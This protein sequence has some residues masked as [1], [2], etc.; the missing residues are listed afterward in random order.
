MT[1]LPASFASAMP[2]EFLLFG[3]LLLSIAFIHWN[4]MAM[5]LVGALAITLY[6]FVFSTFAEGAGVAGLLAHVG[7]EWVLLANLLGLLLGFALLARHVEKSGLPAL[8][9]KYLPNGATGGFLLLVAVFVLSSV[10]DNIAAAIIGAAIAHSV[11]RGRIHVGYLASLVA[12]ANAGGVGSV[13]GDTTTTMIW[14]AGVPPLKVFPGYVAAV[15]AFL[16]TAI[17]ASRQQ[18]AYSPIVADAPSGVRLDAPRLLIVAGVLL[19]AVATNLLM[20]LYLRP[21]ADALPFLAIAV[22]VGLLASAAWRRPDWAELPNALQGAIF[23][24]AL[25]WCASLMPVEKLPVA[26]W[27]STL[28]VGFLS[29]VLDNIPLTALAIKQGGYDWGMLAYAVGFGGSML[30]FGSSA[31][32]AVANRHPEAKS[33]ARWLQHGWHVALAYPVGYFVM[34]ALLGW[35]PFAIDHAAP[36]IATQPPHVAAVNGRSVPENNDVLPDNGTGF[37]MQGSLGLKLPS[38]SAGSPAA[39]GPADNRASASPKS[40][41][42]NKE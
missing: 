17:P 29:A 22:W 5:A 9:P 2:V 40:S 33:V 35:Q 6:Q 38:G 31:G 1:G 14:I 36:A 3:V 27:P 21:H 10:L 4:T 34:L 11:F 26:S 7:H 28:G 20:N 12:C 25:V 42:T 39:S 13:L 41:S 23:L 37:K 19:L 18:H 30:W 16:V 8:L 15:V 32:V 24:L